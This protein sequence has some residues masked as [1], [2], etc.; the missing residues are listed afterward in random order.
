MRPKRP[1]PPPRRSFAKPGRACWAPG[2]LYLESRLAFH[3]G[4]ESAGATL[5]QATENQIL[6]SYRNLQ[7]GMTNELF[8]AQQ[9]S[10]RK[11]MEIYRV[12]LSDPTPADT[13][14][15][16]LESLAVMKT[17]HD[18]AFD[19][20][21]VALLSRK[22][23][24]NAL[25][26]TD[27]AKRR[28]FLQSLP[29]GGRLVALRMLLEADPS[30]IPPQVE[31]LRSAFLLRHPEYARLQKEGERL[32]GDLR[33]GWW[34][35]GKPEASGKLS[36]TWK[37]WADNLD[38]REAILHSIGLG[39][40]ALGVPLPPLVTAKE[41][42]RR[43]PPGHALLVLHHTQGDLLGFLLTA[44][45][46]TQ[47]NIGPAVRVGGSLSKFLRDLGNHDANRPM[48]TEDLASTDYEKS[49]KKLFAALLKGSS[50]DLNATKQLIVVPDDLAWYVPFEA[51]PV[52][53][54]DGTRPL[55]SLTPIRYAPT[56]GLAISAAVAPR[57]VQRTGIVAGSLVPGDSDEVR[58]SMVAQLRSAVDGP[59]G[60]GSDEPVSTAVVGSLLDVLLVLSDVEPDPTEPWAW[61][62]L[63]EGRSGGASLGDWMSLP[64][65]GPQRILLPGMHTMAERG[66]RVPRRHPETA[67][68]GSELFVASCGLMSTGAQ[69]VLLS[70]WRVGGQSTLDLMREFVQELPHTSAADAWQRS[71]QLAME[72]PVDPMLEL[73]VKSQNQDQ[74]LCAS[75]PFFWGGY[76]LVDTG[77]TPPVDEPPPA[78]EPPAAAEPAAAKPPAVEQPPVE[79]QAAENQPVESLPADEQPAEAQ[80]A[81]ALDTID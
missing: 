25:E 22:E 80:P 17:P 39:R 81:G 51:L 74:P 43:L 61:P 71:V 33:D 2:A 30:A 63:P 50:I 70:R 6:T 31:Q 45:A 21:L 79:N 41:A 56:M 52:E 3:S 18:A 16:P 73:R 77:T 46:H 69:T 68:P 11:A 34:P 7:I 15:R 19:R 26:V 9:L 59:I 38:Q 60:L 76:L 57:R 58:E 37:Q 14:F 75:H 35:E 1:S 29:W 49:G 62:P 53:D 72:S 5:A 32:L 78:T 40:T 55:I 24:L 23:T 36:R 13:I 66:F 28:R 67:P 10:D 54:G 48:T 20:W 64:Q 65:F 27:L 12:L 47:W 8:D 4:L 42:A 44:E